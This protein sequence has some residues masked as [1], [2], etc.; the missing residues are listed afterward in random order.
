MI[1]LPRTEDQAREIRARAV[2]APGIIVPRAA[3]HGPNLLWHADLVIS[4]GGTMN[5]EAA[6]LGVPVYSIFRGPSGAV[7]RHLARQGRLMLLEKPDE[8]AAIPLRKRLPIDLSAGQ[9]RASRLVNC[10]VDNILEV[11]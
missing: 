9:T 2:S 1:V 4:G 8:I 5:R 6:C 7:D 10:V 11:I 3:V